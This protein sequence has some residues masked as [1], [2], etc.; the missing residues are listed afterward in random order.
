ML[1]TVA[2]VTAPRG[3]CCGAGGGEEGSVALGVRSEIKLAV[4]LFH[5]L[6]SVVLMRGISFLLRI[7]VGGHRSRGSGN[8]E[9]GPRRPRK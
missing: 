6:G 4:A 7:E 9:R 3:P 1:T 5:C 8:G 2:A